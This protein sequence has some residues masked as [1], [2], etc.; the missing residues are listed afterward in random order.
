MKSGFTLTE[1]L[2]VIMM[3]S[4]IAVI[5][6]PFYNSYQTSVQEKNYEHKL[7]SIIYETKG[8]VN[9]Y[10]LDEL[11][12]IPGN[13]SYE[14]RYCTCYDIENFFL[15]NDLIEHDE[16]RDGRKILINPINNEPIKGNIC[17]DYNIS[18][19]RIETTYN[20]STITNG[21][22]SCSS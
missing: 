17:F 19:K 4:V 6:I 2:V 15:I 20:E 12:F 13:Y 7:Q 11:E 9:E 1:L 18:E 5:V 14:N 10:M 16:I 21:R 8:I 3:F 22:K